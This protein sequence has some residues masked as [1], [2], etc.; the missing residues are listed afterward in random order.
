MV[1][2]MSTLTTKVLKEAMAVQD[3]LLDTI[4]KLS[5]ENE[6]TKEMLRKCNPFKLGKCI[7]CGYLYTDMATKANNHKDNCEYVR[8]TK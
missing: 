1:E 8:L 2:W 4:D 7:S 5:K 6:K 3:G